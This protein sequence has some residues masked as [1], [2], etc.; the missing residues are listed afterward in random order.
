MRVRA[1]SRRMAIHTHARGNRTHIFRGR[2]F[3]RSAIFTRPH[4]ADR[5]PALWKISTQSEEEHAQSV[6]F[7]DQD[8]SN[9]DYTDMDIRVHRRGLKSRRTGDQ[10]RA[11]TATELRAK[12]FPDVIPVPASH[13]PGRV[14]LKIRQT[15]GTTVRGEDVRVPRSLLVRVRVRWVWQFFV[16]QPLQDNGMV[17]APPRP[18]IPP[19]PPVPGVAGGI[20]R[21]AGVRRLRHERRLFGSPK[22][23]LQRVC[24]DYSPGVICSDDEASRKRAQTVGR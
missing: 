17:D 12:G 21:P 23:S 1:G 3:I 7:A 4:R 8:E 18:E 10:I 9:R 19:L 15:A 24:C 20:L 22:R 2:M 16:R 5:S 14:T 6:H 11:D 13:P